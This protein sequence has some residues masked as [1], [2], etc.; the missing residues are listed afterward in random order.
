MR[1]KS[2][3][4]HLE[5]RTAKKAS[6]RQIFATIKKNFD[7]RQTIAGVAEKVK[8][9]IGERKCRDHPQI[10]TTISKLRIKYKWMKKQRKIYNNR[11]KSSSGKRT[12]I[13]KP[14]WLQILDPVLTEIHADLVRL[15]TI[16]DVDQVDSS[17]DDGKS[18]HNESTLD[19]GYYDL[20]PFFVLRS[21]KHHDANMTDDEESGINSRSPDSTTVTNARSANAANRSKSTTEGDL[22]E[23]A[24]TQKSHKTKA[25]ERSL[26]QTSRD[27]TALM[28]KEG[29]SR[30]EAF[31]KFYERQCELNRQHELR[32]K[33]KKNLLR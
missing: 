4:F 33:V 6:N 28:I 3:L 11:I 2:F 23:N 29:K 10:E 27:L 16:D 8:E 19:Y 1:K 17:E 26:E 5:T 25:K 20:P 18:S 22:E 31:M 32:M 15:E 21:N 9:E 30:D 14:Q 24:V 7:D 12:R 13:Q